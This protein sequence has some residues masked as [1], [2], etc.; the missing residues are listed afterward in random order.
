MNL[1]DVKLENLETININNKSYQKVSLVNNSYKLINFQ[2]AKESKIDEI[3]KEKHISS[4]KIYELNK[5]LDYEKAIPKN[6]NITIPN[7]Y[8]KKIEVIID[9]TLNLPY[10][11]RIYD[12]KGLFEE[13]KFEKVDINPKFD[14]NNF[15]EKRIK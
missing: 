6:Y 10:I 1:P 13:F 11:L 9:K 7:A 15:D 12:E 2:V 5:G 4:Y 3:A 8:A 14:E